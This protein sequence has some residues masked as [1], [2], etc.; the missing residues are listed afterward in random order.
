MSKKEPE[1]KCVVCGKSDQKRELLRFILTDE[2]IFS[3][4]S[5]VNECS[6]YLDIFKSGKGRGFY[7]HASSSCAGSR[8]LS[9]R[10][11]GA[12]KRVSR[13]DAQSLVRGE[14]SLKRAFLNMQSLSSGV[15]MG[16]DKTALS[17]NKT[18][19]F[20]DQIISSCFNSLGRSLIRPRKVLRDNLLKISE[21]YKM[22][23]QLIDDIEKR[24][25]VKSQ[26]KFVSID[27]KVRL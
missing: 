26:N 1:R 22:V 8:H 25:E 20:E 19:I 4:D 7:A 12:M 24:S 5:G 2:K 9:G 21:Q 23:V 15:E 18:E 14:L 27:A 3:L 6:I 16:F 10:L 17:D 13:S 11:L